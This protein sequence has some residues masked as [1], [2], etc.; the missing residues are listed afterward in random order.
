MSLIFSVEQYHIHRIDPI[1]LIC[2]SEMDHWV[3]F[4]FWEEADFLPLLSLGKMRMEI[5]LELY[6]SCLRSVRLLQGPSLLRVP[7]SQALCLCPR[8]TQCSSSPCPAPERH[9]WL[10]PHRV[11]FI[12]TL[13]GF[14]RQNLHVSSCIYGAVLNAKLLGFPR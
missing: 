2:L 13:A 6:F 10:Q 7:H 11:L 9:I 1:L 4:F 8:L 12:C 14:L 3:A 5:N